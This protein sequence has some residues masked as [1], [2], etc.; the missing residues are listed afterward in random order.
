MSEPLLPP[1]DEARRYAVTRDSVTWRYM[2]DVRGFAAAGSAL[3]LQVAHPTIAGGVREHSNFK[4][5]P[6]DR[7]LRTVDYVNLMVYGGP[8]TAARTGRAL[9]E[10]HKRIK[11]IDPQGRRYHA[12]EPEAFAWVHATLAYAVVAA[13][14][15]FGRPMSDGEIEQYWREWRRLGRLLGIRDGELPADWAGFRAYV[16][17]MIAERLEDND[18]VRDVLASVTRPTESPLRR[19]PDRVWATATLPMHQIISVATVG[20][21]P[22]ALRAKL[23]LELSSSQ[24]ARLRALGLLSRASTPV[25]PG[26]LKVSG[27]LYLQRRQRA[28][29]RGQFAGPSTIG[30]SARSANARAA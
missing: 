11:G 21:L 16:D 6:W 5:E 3:L 12:L 2:S 23:D 18:V 8:E 9:R 27:P 13:H 7:L 4:E 20:L 1:V 22:P 24:Q 19:V 17:W 30:T 14:R 25:L 26:T 10:G 28:I 15:R 29:D